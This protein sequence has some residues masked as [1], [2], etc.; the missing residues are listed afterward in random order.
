MGFESFNDE[1][2][3]PTKEGT[4]EDSVEEKT[5]AEV[6][7]STE[8]PEK[9]D[10]EVSKTISW[11][12]DIAIPNDEGAALRTT[13]DINKLLEIDSLSQLIKHVL[14]SVGTREHWLYVC[15]TTKVISF[16]QVYV[17]NLRRARGKPLLVKD[18]TEAQ[19]SAK[20]NKKRAE[21]TLKRDNCDALVDVLGI[22]N[23]H[24]KQLLIPF[25]LP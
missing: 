18:L 13:V 6:K 3:A 21:N 2:P 11:L 10:E 19:L 15:K 23:Q 20:W 9:K 24:F 25:S 4:I 14:K 16:M 5:P 1:T 17:N 8:L 7:D 22:S 12:Q